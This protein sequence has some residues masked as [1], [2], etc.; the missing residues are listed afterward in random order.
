MQNENVVRTEVNVLKIAESYGFTLD[1]IHETTHRGSCPKCGGHDRFII[2]VER[3]R[4]Y[5][6]KSEG[7]TGNNRGDA[8]QLVM[9]VEGC[10]YVEANRLLSSSAL[11]R[12]STVAPAT[13][14][15]KE[16]T[17]TDPAIILEMKAIHDLAWQHNTEGSKSSDFLLSRGINRATQ[18][19][20]RMGLSC[21]EFASGY[22]TPTVSL[23]WYDDKKQFCGI[24]HR[25]IKP[26]SKDYKTMFPKGMKWGSLL[27]GWHTH[28]AANDTLVIVE[29]ILN[30]PSIY[31]AMSGKFNVLTPG[32]E[33]CTFSRWPMDAIRRHKRIFVW[34]DKPEVAQVWADAI[35]EGAIPMYSRISADGIKLDANELLRRDVLRAQLLLRQ[36]FAVA[37][38]H[39]GQIHITLR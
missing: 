31:Q 18:E 14:K 19:A 17:P 36:R 6:R 7:H 26:L 28:Q 10:N 3:N 22:K 24:S 9:L 4:W 39:P 23:P 12:T 33:N 35:G 2:N 38:K 29:G 32:S 15:A 1:S 27:C 37:G 30:A 20:W 25:L 21:Y 11:A 34:A 16:I 13:P 8:I 5:C